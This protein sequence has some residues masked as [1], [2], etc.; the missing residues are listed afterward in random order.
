MC[1][2]THPRRCQFSTT[3]FYMLPHP[4]RAPIASNQ[5]TRQ[6]D[7]RTQLGQKRL[8]KPDDR[9]N[10]TMQPQKCCEIM[11]FSFS[12]V[13][14]PLI[15]HLCM[16]VRACLREGERAGEIGGDGKHIVSRCI[17]NSSVLQALR[18]RGVSLQTTCVSAHT[19]VGVS[20]QQRIFTCCLI[21]SEHPN[22]IPA[23]SAVNQTNS[24]L[25]NAHE[26]TATNKY[27]NLLLLWHDT[28][29]HRLDSGGG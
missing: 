4:Q 23:R 13:S 11:Y 14:F 7:H 8:L 21:L 1:I 25:E 9:Q 26:Y 16:C 22:Q 10:T 28:V 2:R 19:E 17:H 24:A 29:M 5:P 15:Q 12:Y 27:H 3:N 6:S 20:S 18:Q